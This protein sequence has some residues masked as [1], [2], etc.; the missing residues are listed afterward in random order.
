M[1]RLLFGTRAMS[2]RQLGSSSWMHSL[3]SGSAKAASPIMKVSHLRLVTLIMTFDRDVNGDD[4][5]VLLFSG[6][7]IQSQ[8]I[9]TQGV[10]SRVCGARV[11]LKATAIMHGS[12]CLQWELAHDSSDAPRDGTFDNTHSTVQC[13]TLKNNWGTTFGSHCAC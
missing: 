10:C 8:R 7:Q 9:Y 13:D 3:K 5:L 2:S 6:R 1:S 11:L 12:S 4:A